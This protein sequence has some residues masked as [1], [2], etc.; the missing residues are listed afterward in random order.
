MFSSWWFQPLWKICSSK[1]E[2]SPNRG[3]KKKYLSCHHPV[4]YISTCWSSQAGYL[5]REL[6]HPTLVKGTKIIFDT[7][8]GGDMF[9][10]FFRG[11]FMGWFGSNMLASSLTID[12]A[13]SIYSNIIFSLHQKKHPKPPSR[14][15]PTN[16]IIK[17]SYFTL[18]NRL[19]NQ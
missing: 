7:T 4:L 17:Q 14:W 6:T 10:G 13:S 18:I 12:M 8:F 9:V 15:S 11:N 5:P 16:I 3:E 2:S 19:I 1:W